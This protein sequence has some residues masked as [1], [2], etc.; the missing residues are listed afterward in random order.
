MCPGCVKT[1]TKNLSAQCYAKS[2]V[3]RLVS[4]VK[5]YVGMRFSALFLAAYAIKNVFTQPRPKADVAKVRL[6]RFKYHITN[7]H[8]LFA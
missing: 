6:N 8:G 1:L 3:D 7:G 2:E 5:F 4:R